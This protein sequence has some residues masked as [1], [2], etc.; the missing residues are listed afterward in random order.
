MGV[1]EITQ[2]QYQLVMGD[3]P[4]SYK[5]D[6]RPV[7]CVSWNDIRGD[8]STYNWPNVTTVNSS[9]FIGKLQAKTSLNFD[10]PTESQWEYTCRARTTSDYNNG[11]SSDAD[12]KTLGRF[13]GNQADGRGGYGEHTTV[14]SYA[15]NAWGLYDMH[16]NVLEWCLDWYGGLNGDAVLDWTGVHS[17]SSRVLRGGYWN[18]S[19]YRAGSSYRSKHNNPSDRSNFD[20]FRL[21]R[22]LAE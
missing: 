14:G 11:G 20:G 3:N 2:K 22:T 16:G 6:M 7:E 10:L 18:N 1:F 15:P 12:W 9:S 5:G 21:S 4:S 13:N 17:G 8:S 19:A